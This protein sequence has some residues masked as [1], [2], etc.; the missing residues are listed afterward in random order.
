MSLD[1]FSQTEIVGDT[2]NIGY[3]YELEDSMASEDKG[4]HHFNPYYDEDFEDMY[5][6]WPNVK[7]KPLIFKRTNDEFFPTLHTWYF[8]NVDSTVKLVI[9]NWGFANTSFEIAEAKLAKGLLS[10]NNF[11]KKYKREKKFLIKQLGK[12]TEEKS[13][14]TAV[15]TITKTVWDFSDKR[16]VL[17]MRVDRN[18]NQIYLPDLNETKFIPNSRIEIKIIFKE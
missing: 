15:G 8:Y 7:K 5:K 1:V 10:V 6:V 14:E 18:M 11:N 17:K 4:F 2:L 16:I 12:P 9:Y 13:K 3:I